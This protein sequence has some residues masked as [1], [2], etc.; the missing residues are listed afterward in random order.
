MIKFK[1]V[2]L[3]MCVLAMPAL[4]KAQPP[5]F[6][7]ESPYGVTDV[8]FDD[9]IYILIAVAVI[10]GGVKIWSHNKAEKNKEALL[11]H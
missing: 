4:L 5:T 9:N 3:M 11:Q 1:R 10:Y 6:D 7:D 2:F 8:P